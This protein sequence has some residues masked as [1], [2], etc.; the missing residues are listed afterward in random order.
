M[1][2]WRV[3]ECNPIVKAGS[4]AEETHFGNPVV[5]AVA[6]AE[7]THQVSDDGV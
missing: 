5:K 1:R 6:I 7:E 3:D 2:N 4:I